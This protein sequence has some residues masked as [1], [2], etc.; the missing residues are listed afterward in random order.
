MNSW[1]VTPMSSQ[2]SASINSLK[3][4]KER[5]LSAKPV[6]LNRTKC[7][8]IILYEPLTNIVKNKNINSN[9]VYV[10]RHV[11]ACF[12]ICTYVYLGK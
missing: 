5:A 11:D 10:R 4:R 9:S 12:Y 7:F 8:P 6:I 3:G 1:I 2:K